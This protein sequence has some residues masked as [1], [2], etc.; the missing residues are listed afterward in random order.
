[1]IGDLPVTAVTRQHVKAVLEPIWLDKHKTAI[2]IRA[3]IE[4]VLVWAAA[5]DHAADLTAASHKVLVELLPRVDKVA[6]AA[7][8]LAAM[9]CAEVPGFMSRLRALDTMQ[10]R[11]FEFT[12][13]CATRTGETLGAIWDE[14]DLEAATWTI[15]PG[16]MKSGKEH[17]VVLSKA[18][19][20]L[21]RGLQSDRTG[22]VFAKQG[23]RLGRSTLQHV[24]ERLKLDVTVHGFRSAFADFVR[25]RTRTEPEVRELCL[26]HAIGN[27]T[28]RSYSRSELL[29][30]RAIVM[31][32]WAGFC[33]R[34]PVA[35]D[36]IVTIGKG[37]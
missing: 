14:I 37:R 24:L 16:R 21:L 28:L 30:K 22:F 9:P 12:V 10:A 29:A 20:A 15:P 35:N 7:V 11:A 25:E 34:P 17:V 26:A 3:R 33:A 36:K 6:K 31:E 1:M 8:H 13:L 27:A 5:N 2:R 23:R 4:R 18:A 32:A 19:V